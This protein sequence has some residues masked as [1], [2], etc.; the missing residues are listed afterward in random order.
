MNENTAERCT[1]AVQETP[2]HKRLS[3]LPNKLYDVYSCE[4]QLNF[5]FFTSL[6]QNIILIVAQGMCKSPYQ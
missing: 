1:K 5:F 2:A 4:M 3:N 6:H